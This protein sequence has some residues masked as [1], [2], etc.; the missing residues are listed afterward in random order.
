MLPSQRRHKNS[1]QIS[2][3]GPSLEPR[4]EAAEVVRLLVRDEPGRL[5]RHVHLPMEKIPRERKEWLAHNGLLRLV[6]Q[7]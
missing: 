5:G 2:E 6:E 3:T 7:Q 4:D 1:R